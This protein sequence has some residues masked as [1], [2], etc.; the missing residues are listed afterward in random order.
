[1]P[2]IGN[3][4]CSCSAPVGF[5]FRLG[6]ECYGVNSSSESSSD[7][8]TGIPRACDRH[9]YTLDYRNPGNLTVIFTAATG[10]GRDTAA[11]TAKKNLGK[12]LLTQS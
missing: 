3:P 8:C 12:L 10:D 11:T 6:V 1:M 2:Q 5:E 9:R 7:R 4:C